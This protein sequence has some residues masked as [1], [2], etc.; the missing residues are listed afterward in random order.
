MQVVCPHCLTKNRLPAERATEDP[1]CG[2]LFAWLAGTLRPD[3]E[4][5]ALPKPPATPKTGIARS[6]HATVA[7]PRIS[8]G[9]RTHLF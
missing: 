2:I 1:R 6:R 8:S 4:V 9:N 5:V 7:I 3:F